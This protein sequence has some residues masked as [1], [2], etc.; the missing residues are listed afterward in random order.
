MRAISMSHQAR[1]SL[2]PKLNESGP[3]G[4]TNLVPAGTVTSAASDTR[5]FPGAPKP[6]RSK[7]RGPRPPPFPSMPPRILVRN[8]PICSSRMSNPSSHIQILQQGHEAIEGGFDDR[9]FVERN[10]RAFLIGFDLVNDVL[11]LFRTNLVV[12]AHPQGLEHLLAQRNQDSL[13]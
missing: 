5:S 1:A 8:P 12:F 11:D 7:T 6:C 2:G 13:L 10:E 3:S 9:L 4:N